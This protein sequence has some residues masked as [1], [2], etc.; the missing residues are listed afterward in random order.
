M[1]AARNHDPLDLAWKR[2][3][4]EVGWSLIIVFILTSGLVAWILI[5]SV[6]SSLESSV[7]GY[8]NGLGTYF[9]VYYGSGTRCEPIFEVC[10]KTLP[11][12]VTDKIGAIPG[13]EKIYP[14]IVNGTDLFGTTTE[15]YN[16]QNTTLKYDVGEGTALIGGPRG[17]PTSL[18]ALETG[19]L[20][21]DEPTF[22]MAQF[23]SSPY[24]L[25]TTQLN[26]SRPVAFGCY[27]CPNQPLVSAKFNATAVGILALNP[28]FVRIGI[29]WNSSFVSQ[30]LGPTT[31]RQT[32]EGNGSNYVI[33]KVG[34][35]ADL[36]RAVN[37]TEQLIQAPQ[38]GAFGVTYDQALSQSLQSLTAQTAPLYQLIGVVSLI[39]VAGL[40]FLV[41][42]LI[43]GRRDWEVGVYLTQGWSWGEVY[44]LY[45]VYFL[46][47][48]L[49]SFVIAAVASYIAVG[50]F[51]AT[52]NIFGTFVTFAAS[53]VPLYLLSGLA[54]TFVLAFFAS[55]T[56]VRRQRR[57]GLDNIVR[58]Y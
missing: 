57:M 7:S 16:G 52:Y 41:A 15:V 39:A 37:A 3:L 6:A 17:F 18:I 47:T 1:K 48:S 13:V 34:S 9:V 32:W 5:P 12:N 43:A 4:R 38:Y 24:T 28:V 35:V 2:V 21:G 53:L 55:Y 46:I 56:I 27:L 49:M 51:A 22:V 19:R 36:P 40:S 45:S 50:Y 20:P 58:E 42:H 10:A 25:A 14:I 26:Q 30:K 33:V 8:S 23:L 29:L 54:F 11:A 31:Y 44:V